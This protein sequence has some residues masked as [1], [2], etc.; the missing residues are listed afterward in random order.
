MGGMTLASIRPGRTGRR[1]AVLLGMLLLCLA[2]VFSVSA[3]AYA[4]ELTAEGDTV[5]PTAAGQE[6]PVLDYELNAGTAALC[7]GLVI[8]FYVFIFWRS[9]KEFKKIIEVHFGPRE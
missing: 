2:L 8:A 9:E 5:I 3:V 6:A 1:A 4:V 7:L